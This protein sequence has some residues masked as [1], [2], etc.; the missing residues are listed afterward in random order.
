MPDLGAGRAL[1]HDLELA[2]LAASGERAAFGELVR[3][4]GSAVRRT[5]RRMG[6]APGVADETA[7]DGFL[8]AFEQISEFRGEG[9]F[10][11][12]VKGLA[13]RLYLKRSARAGLVE[14]KLPDCNPKA[15]ARNRSEDLDATLEALPSVERICVS[16]C[17]GAGLTHADVATLL[18]TSPANV[19]SWIGLGMEHLRDRLA[20]CLPTGAEGAPQLV[21]DLAFDLAIERRFADVAPL[22]DAD[23]FVIRVA[24]RLNRGWTF[25]QFLIGGLGIVGGLI[26][27]AELLGSGLIGR[28]SALRAQSEALIARLGDL[29]EVPRL[30]SIQTSTEAEI[31]WM[32][33]VL[34]IVALALFV[35]RAL[36]NL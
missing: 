28:A 6:A 30:I 20:A 34:A 21:S 11:S 9:T 19:K 31:L 14:L 15:G 17:F 23:F 12:W 7:M 2:A 25:R 3:R 10:Q 29:R 33:V 27:G 8:A 16:A 22:P 36:R 18:K 32:S 13:A 4:H 24:D 5:L 1:A 35:T 26:G